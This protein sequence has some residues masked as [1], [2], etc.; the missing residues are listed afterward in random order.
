MDLDP[1]VNLSSDPGGN[2]GNMKGFA[3]SSTNW[4]S[5]FEPDSRVAI[6]WRFSYCTL[7]FRPNASYSHYMKVDMNW[8][9]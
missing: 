7:M 9:L 3:F 8:N 6:A 2:A 5:V 4:D 1:E